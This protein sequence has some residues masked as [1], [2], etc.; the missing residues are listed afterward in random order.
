MQK[1]HP[2]AVKVVRIS[3]LKHYPVLG[4]SRF[5][6]SS[7]YSHLI[8]AMEFC[9]VHMLLNDVVLTTEHRMI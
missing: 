3:L 7:Q 6:L 1:L 8:N 5:I 4:M 2:P 9:V